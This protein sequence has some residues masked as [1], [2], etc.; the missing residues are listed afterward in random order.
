MKAVLS[1]DE[2]RKSENITINECN[3]SSIELVEKAAGIIK[4]V[5]DERFPDASKFMIVAGG[6]NNGADGLACA[7]LLAECNKKVYVFQ[8]SGKQSEVNVAK[9][10]LLLNAAM[11]NVTFTNE[12]RSDCDV[13]I[14]A[15]FGIGLNRDLADEDVELISQINALGKPVIS[16]D[17]PSGLNSL[18]GIP[19]PVCVK[20]DITITFGFY[21]KGLLCGKGPD[22]YK[23]LILGDIGLYELKSN[24]NWYMLDKDDVKSLTF[25][26]KTAHKGTYGKVLVVAGSEKIYGAAYLC[27]KASFYS[28]AGMVKVITHTNNKYS[29][30]A[31]LPEAMFEF[32]DSGISYDIIDSS[33][34]WADTIIIGCGLGTG[35]HS[36]QIMNDIIYSSELYDKNLIIDAD[37]LNIL[38]ANPELFNSLCHKIK[39][40][41][42]VTVFTPHKKELSRLC[43]GLYISRP[44]EFFHKY[45]I[46]IV[47]KDSK[48]LIHGSK[49][50]VNNTG[51]DGMATAGS[52]DVLAGTIGGVLYRLKN[53]HNPEKAVAVAVYIHGL[54][55]D[56]AADEMSCISMTSADILRCIPIAW[57]CFIS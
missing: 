53:I 7:R 32:Y 40:N 27:S 20:S 17:I 37:G 26:Q 15:L 9:M 22:Y 19:M 44:D 43:E 33:L 25:S 21:K 39:N 5:I 52:G 1:P 54:A 51:N 13:L 56:L 35:N 42:L 50:Y 29:F 30:E 2:V 23:E 28:G 46:I 55:G 10:N 6:G 49:T 45:N 57:K 4:D 41:K 48:T 16:A 38:S 18:T 24:D 34:A 47:E 11:S 14:D 8:R 36:L 3:I 12:L 31:N